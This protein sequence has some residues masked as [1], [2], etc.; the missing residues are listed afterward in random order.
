MGRLGSSGEQQATWTPN[1]GV[2]PFAGDCRRF[3]GGALCL[4]PLYPG[5]GNPSGDW[6]T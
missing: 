5:R 2:F 1:P 3:S 6:V 4:K